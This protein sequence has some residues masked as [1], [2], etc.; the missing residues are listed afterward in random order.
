MDEVP[1]DQEV[2]DVAHAF[3][4]AEFVFQTLPERAV[5]LGVAFLDPFAA[6][7]AQVSGGCHAVRHVVFGKLGNAEFDFDVA[8]LGDFVGVFKRF[9]GI[10]K[11]GGHFFF[12]FYI[13][14]AALVAHTVAVPDLFVG[15]DAEQDVVR[16]GVLRHDV[17]RVVCA[18]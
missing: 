5:V 6:E 15:L 13:I 8:A 18:D 11:E 4:D 12:G 3:D 16:G 2:V 7:L 9:A 14:L 1:N 17:V 10:G